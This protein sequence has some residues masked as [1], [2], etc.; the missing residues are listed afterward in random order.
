MLQ[1]APGEVPGL[2]AGCPRW[3]LPPGHGPK[4]GCLQAPAAE[5]GGRGLSE[6]GLLWGCSQF[7]KRS[8]E[9]KCSWGAAGG[10]GRRAESLLKS[11]GPVWPRT[12]AQS[13]LGQP[14]EEP[15]AVG[16]PPAPGVSALTQGAGWAPT[17]GPAG[18]DVCWARRLQLTALNPKGLLFPL[19]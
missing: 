14:P 5:R 17:G 7:P 3:P 13:C 16:A 4:K 15:S 9:R 2:G 11:Q 8:W 6:L 18:E 12:R 1:R 10:V 19:S